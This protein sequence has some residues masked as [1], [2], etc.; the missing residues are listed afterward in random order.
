[1]DSP[2]AKTRKISSDD[3][4]DAAERVVVRLGAVGLSIDEVA[5]EAGAIV[6]WDRQPLEGFE[7]APIAEV[8]AGYDLVVLDHPH[9][10]DALAAG[11]VYVMPEGVGVADAGTGLAFVDD[12]GELIGVLPPQESAVLVLSGADSARVDA[13]LLAAGGAELGTPAQLAQTLVERWA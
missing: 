9:L 3:V 5:R 10:G 8:C 13:A 12:A 6:S 1:M 7:S 2:L 4:L 11:T